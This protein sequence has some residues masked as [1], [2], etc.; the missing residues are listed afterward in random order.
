MEE[1][2][3]EEENTEEEEEQEELGFGPFSA[4][5]WMSIPVLTPDV[6]KND[7]RCW[8]RFGVCC[9]PFHFVGFGYQ[10]QF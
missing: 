6:E 3:E 1:E 7:S 4:G 2:E 9:G 5:V 10:S 8:I